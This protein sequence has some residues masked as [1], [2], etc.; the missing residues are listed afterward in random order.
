M[1]QYLSPGVYVEEKD[2]GPRPIVGVSTS[3]AGAVGVTAKGPTSGKPRL[4][5]S[6]ADFVAYFGGYTPEPSDPAIVNDWAGSDTEGG[7][8]WQFAHSVEGFFL[9][10]GQQLFVKRVFASSAAASKENLGGGW[11]IPL[12]A[13]AKRGATTLL[14]EHLIG[15]DDGGA[16]PG[17][18][19]HLIRGDT[20]ADL[21]SFAVGSYDPVRNQ[22]TLDGG[23][24]VPQDLEAGRDFVEVHPR[25]AAPGPVADADATIVIDANAKGA[26]GDAISVQIKPMV[27][28]SLGILSDPGEGAAVF[29]RVVVAA[30]AGATTVTVAKVTGGLDDTTRRPFTVRIGDMRTQVTNAA[31]NGTNANWVDLTVAAI[32]AAVAVGTTVQRLLKSN[33]PASRVT[34]AAAVGDTTVTVRKIPGSLDAANS[35]PFNVTIAGT[36][37]QVTAIADNA[38][39]T[40]W[41]DLTVAALAAAVPV[42][43]SVKLGP[44]DL[45]YVSNAGRLY[46][47]AVVELD[48]GGRKDLT[49]VSSVSGSLV[50]LQDDLK[51]SYLEGDRLRLVE[52][53]VL[54]HYAP[55]GEAPVDEEFT[56]LRLVRD[57]S[58]STLIDVVSDRSAY[59]DLRAGA[60]YDDSDITA[61][62]TA[63]SGAA[64]QLSGGDDKLADLRVDDF[65]GVDGGSG[66]RTGI[67]AL[68]DIDEIAI[69]LVPGIWSRTVQGAL[70]AHCESLKDR[71]AILDPKDGL[72]IQEVMDE[73]Q[74][75]D[76]KYAALYYPWLI[77]RDPQVGRDVP[78]APS[79][80]MA[81]IYARVDDERG[82]HKAP[83]NEVIRAI[84]GFQADV[85]KR[86]QDLL[87]PV[88][89]N[90]LRF[91]PGRGRRVWGA[92]A[93]TSDTL[94]RYINVRRLFIM[95]RES[96]EEGTAF[97]VFEPND[98]DLWARVRL[99][100][101]QFLETQRRSGALVGRTPAEAYF[102]RCDEKT[103]TQDDIDQGRLICEIGIAPSKPA[104]FV[105]FRIQQK[106]RELQPA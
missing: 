33:T 59:V 63:I 6:F 38:G 77:V 16:N 74:L 81:G 65:V 92:R 7:R 36:Q 49:V 76:T 53:R 106:T 52:A 72:G 39:N 29:S 4:V 99:T 19:F 35:T 83:A 37:M 15:L 101:T 88:A 95:I 55:A 66:N 3:I 1:P 5:T 12:K 48:N 18:Q 80:H 103:M 100:I 56:N 91:F 105:I 84:N 20:Q 70:I 13:D 40:A 57:G 87:N 64:Q 104:E 32:P 97:V 43:A 54:V 45:I 79:G 42:G 89:I 62:P 2:P 96:I 78:L 8:W 85:T 31:I 34:V 102:V 24:Q 25:P 58:P 30:A 69:C 90:A 28:A 60:S 75:I 61:F 82:V 9:N 47:G 21:G 68:E 27:G 44:A 67:A 23:A 14:L 94:W 73:R 50:T 26:W 41:A 22:I 93:L 86:E 51:Q 17:T 98:P 71:F 46:G 10:G 11:V